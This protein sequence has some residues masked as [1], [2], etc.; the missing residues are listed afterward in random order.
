MVFFTYFFETCNI[1]ID[2]NYHRSYI[3]NLQVFAAASCY[4]ELQT[5]GCT[6]SAVSSLFV[7]DAAEASA[8]S[9]AAVVVHGVESADPLLVD[10]VAYQC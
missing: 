5:P 1:T 8:C 2:H 7:S 10:G 6:L 3:I 9:V 4:E